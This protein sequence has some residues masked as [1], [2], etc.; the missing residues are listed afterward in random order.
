MSAS[1]KRMLKAALALAP[2]AHNPQFPVTSLT[3]L[4]STKTRFSTRTVTNEISR[5]WPLQKQKQKKI[6]DCETDLGIERGRRQ[7]SV[8]EQIMIIRRTNATLG[9]EHD[10]QKVMSKQ[11]KVAHQPIQSKR[12]AYTEEDTAHTE[13][14]LESE[15]AKKP[16]DWIKEQQPIGINGSK[17]SCHSPGACKDKF[18]ETSGIG[19]PVTYLTLADTSAENPAKCKYCGLRFYSNESH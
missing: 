16:M 7:Q 18:G 14:W 10:G 6:G 2:N 17:V 19:A 4:M 11:I 12:P 1:A 9:H 3:R 8:S 13:K 5:G 15:S